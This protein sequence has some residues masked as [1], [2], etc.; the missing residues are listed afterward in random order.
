MAGYVSDKIWWPREVGR[1]PG[2]LWRVMSGTASFGFEISAKDRLGSTA[3][4]QI[5][6]Q[7][8][9]VQIG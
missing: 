3:A 5:A 1:I 6:F 9:A 8:W 2:P 4:V 7:L